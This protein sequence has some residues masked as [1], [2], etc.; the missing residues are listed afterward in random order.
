MVD[1]YLFPLGG[2]GFLDSGFTQR[3]CFVVGYFLLVSGCYYFSFSLSSWHYSANGSDFP[4]SIFQ[5]SKAVEWESF[6]KS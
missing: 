6:E 3:D 2:F 1:Y 5:K 4:Y